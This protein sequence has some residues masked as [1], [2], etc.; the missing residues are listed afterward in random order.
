MRLPGK[1]QRCTITANKA[2][3][4]YG[5]EMLQ[6]DRDLL[7]GRNQLAQ[8]ISSNSDVGYYRRHSLT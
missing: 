7:L 8:S 5:F 1:T 3:A 6:S 2:D 4:W